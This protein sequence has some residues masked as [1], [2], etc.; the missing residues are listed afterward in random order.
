VNRKAATRLFATIAERGRRVMRHSSVLEDA[1]TEAAT[2]RACDLHRHATQTVFGEGPGDARVMLV[3]EQPGDAEDLAGRPFV[4]PA[5]RLLD[6]ALVEAGIERREVWVTNAVKH[7]KFTLRGRRRIHQKPDRG[8]IAAC[9]MWLDRELDLVAPRRV[10]A[11]GATAAQAL[12][13]RAVT[14]AKERGRWQKLAPQRQLLV[15]V[16]PSYLLRIE[17]PQAQD[18]ERER[19]V[20]DLRRIA[21]ALT[22]EPPTTPPGPQLSLL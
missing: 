20:A 9:R 14:I 12:L 7:F 5:G 19:F 13:G 21:D 4:G 15:T 10:V 3:G 6:R 2:C 11:L 1:R 8:E 17:N 18:L 16:H 22:E